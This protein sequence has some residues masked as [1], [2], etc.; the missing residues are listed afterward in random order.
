[1][2][3]HEINL[4]FATVAVFR[5]GPTGTAGRREDANVVAGLGDVSR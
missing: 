3:V 1:M 5:V 4:V 2:L